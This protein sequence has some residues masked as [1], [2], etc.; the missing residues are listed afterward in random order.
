MTDKTRQLILFAMKFT[1]RS[2]LLA[3]ILGTLY[4]KYMKHKQ[5]PSEK[6]ISE[7]FYSRVK[8]IDFSKFVD[9]SQKPDLNVIIITVDCLR[10]RNMSFAGNE[11]ETTPSRKNPLKLY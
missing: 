8:K 5:Y 1:K 3:K 4:H 9:I 10:Y 2:K 6:E 11:R 7:E